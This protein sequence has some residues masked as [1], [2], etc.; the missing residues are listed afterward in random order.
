MRQWTI[1][2]DSLRS[3]SKKSSN[4]KNKE[5]FQSMDITNDSQAVSTDASP[6]SY[7]AVND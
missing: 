4:I 5:P 7:V 6:S 3:T 1:V 2:Y